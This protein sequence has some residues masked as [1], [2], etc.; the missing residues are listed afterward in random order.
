MAFKFY[1]HPFWFFSL[2]IASASTILFMRL[3]YAI[4]LDFYCIEGLLCVIISQLKVL[5]LVQLKGL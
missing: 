2:R 1:A 4:V 5:L 3:K